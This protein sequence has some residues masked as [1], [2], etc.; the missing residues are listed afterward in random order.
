MPAKDEKVAILSLRMIE[1]FRQKLIAIEKE[2]TANSNDLD[3][4]LRYGIET[5]Q[6]FLQWTNNPEITSEEICKFKQG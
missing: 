2:S 1:E 6:L 4:H 3:G 5:L